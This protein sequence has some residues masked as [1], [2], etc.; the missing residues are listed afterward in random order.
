M[1]A[2]WALSSL[3]SV[4]YDLELAQA[5]RS[6]KADTYKRNFVSKS[7]AGSQV[8][9]YLRHHGLLSRVPMTANAPDRSCA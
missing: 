7:A 1:T 4:S 3:L 2:V 5:A 8:E 6:A 9:M